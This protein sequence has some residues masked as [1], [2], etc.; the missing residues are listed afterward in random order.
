MRDE[1]PTGPRRATQPHTEPVIPGVR[2]RRRRTPRRARLISGPRTTGP[3]EWGHVTFCCAAVAHGSTTCST[4]AVPKWMPSSS[5]NG[6][7]TADNVSR[8][9][10]LVHM[11]R[12]AFARL[13]LSALCSSLR[14]GRGLTG[15]WLDN[16]VRG[17]SNKNGTVV[18]STPPTSPGGEMSVASSSRP[19]ATR[20]SG[21][22]LA[23]TGY[24]WGD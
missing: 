20:R 10:A 1:L 24:S 5:A 3:V 2:R 19:T 16:T 17:R 15:S 21:L 9:I 6:R 23:D 22:A 12:P 18:N 14:A 8:S 13:I 4:H 7:T 11:A